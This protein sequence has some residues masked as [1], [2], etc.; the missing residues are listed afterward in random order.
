MTGK[1]VDRQNAIQRMETSIALMDNALQACY[2]TPDGNHREQTSE[3]QKRADTL[4]DG[5]RDMKVM[6]YYVKNGIQCPECM[7]TGTKGSN[8]CS[9]CGLELVT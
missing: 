6:L 7:T 5:I 8:Y 2:F 4:F 1:P 9:N 3:T